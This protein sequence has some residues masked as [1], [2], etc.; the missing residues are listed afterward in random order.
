MTNKLIAVLLMLLTG[1]LSAAHITDKLVVGLFEKPDIE[2]DPIRLIDSGTAL[3]VLS[4]KNGL[5]K[6][7]LHD[8]TVGWV[9]SGYVTDDKPATALLLEA[10]AEIRQ[11]KNR[12]AEVGEQQSTDDSP[13]T[14]NM[15]TVR[16]A[17]VVQELDKAEKRI[18]ELESSLEK[19]KAQEVAQDRLQQL[20]LAVDHAYK[21]LSGTA[22]QSSTQVEVAQNQLQSLS[23]DSLVDI[24]GIPSWIF[25]V[26][27]I[28]TL[29]L[30]FVGGWV[31]LDQRL[32]QRY[33]G[34]LM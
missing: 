11:L 26:L 29:L 8:S 28:I 17:I 27:P 25:L 3:D 1:S 6:V 9:E 2:A 34:S 24:K 14:A 4:R 19:V 33:G 23:V 12:L 5:L 18:A 7:R 32:R 10:K 21:A 22:T 13:K 20:Q 31:Y 30:G 16:E 15:P